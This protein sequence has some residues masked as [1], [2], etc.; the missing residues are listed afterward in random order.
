M[1]DKLAERFLAIVR[2]MNQAT[3]MDQLNGIVEWMDRCDAEFGPDWAEYHAALL[4]MYETRMDYLLPH[5]RDL[6]KI[7]HDCDSISG[8]IGVTQERTEFFNDIL[9]DEVARSLDAGG[10][11]RVSYLMELVVKHSQSHAELM[12]FSIM[13]GSVKERVFTQKLKMVDMNKPVDD[14]FINDILK[15]ED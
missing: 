12:M 1:M 5:W 13:M 2:N 8:A 14:D 4:P 15:G 3:T 6:I 9:W 11:S 7:D 10:T